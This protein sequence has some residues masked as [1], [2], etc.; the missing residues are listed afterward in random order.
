VSGNIIDIF[1]LKMSFSLFN[2]YSSNILEEKS[3][4][5]FYFKLTNNDAV[6]QIVVEIDQIY[7]KT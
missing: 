1:K 2:L 4:F 3:T 7:L 6:P 5:F